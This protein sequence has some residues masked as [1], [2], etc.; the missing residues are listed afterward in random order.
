MS[1]KQTVSKH[2]L[3]KQDKR[4]LI[5]LYKKGFTYKEIGKQLGATTRQIKEHVRR[6]EKNIIKNFTPEEDQIIREKYLSGMVK[7]WQIWAYIPNKEPYMI[8]NRIK[9]LLKKN[10]MYYPN[11]THQ[12]EENETL[13]W[14]PIDQ[15]IS[16]LEL[17]EIDIHDNYFNEEEMPLERNEFLVDSYYEIDTRL[18]HET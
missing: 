4:K 14:D 17:N 3:S 18:E 15:P 13:S 12:K 1:E 16:Y 9:T 8:R 11:T 6:F 5:F 7:E 2:F 10:L